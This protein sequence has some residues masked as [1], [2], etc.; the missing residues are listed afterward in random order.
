MKKKQLKDLKSA[1]SGSKGSE[2]KDRLTESL[3]SSRHKHSSLSRVSPFP[4]HL[5]SKGQ[6]HTRVQDRQKK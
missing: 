6:G 1:I 2:L 3:E 5:K 4:S